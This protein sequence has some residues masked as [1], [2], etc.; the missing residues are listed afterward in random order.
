MFRS[1]SVAQMHAERFPAGKA[2]DISREKILSKRNIYFTIMFGT[3]MSLSRFPKQP[4]N[5]TYQWDKL[6]RHCLLHLVRGGCFAPEDGHSTNCHAF[7][8]C[9]CLC[10]LFLQITPVSCKDFSFWWTFFLSVC[11]GRTRVLQMCSNTRCAIRVG[12]WPWSCC[13]VCDGKDTNPNP[14][15]AW[16]CYRWFNEGLILSWKAVQLN[17]FI[18]ASLRKMPWDDSDWILLFICETQ[19]S[20]KQKADWR[21]FFSFSLFWIADFFFSP[22]CLQ[23][24]IAVKQCK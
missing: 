21:F 9:C 1:T 16:K 8:D 10:E 20:S 23:E 18:V 14:G 15:S 2:V 24:P 19:L 6:C 22:M 13:C 7:G 11:T 4:F 17:V 5:Q 12:K 3:C